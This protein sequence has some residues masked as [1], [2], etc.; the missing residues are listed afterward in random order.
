MAEEADKKYDE[1][2]CSPPAWWMNST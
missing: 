2:T 1:V